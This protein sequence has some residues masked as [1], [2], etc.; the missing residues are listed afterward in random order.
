VSVD[1]ASQ[2][3]GVE[4]EVVDAKCLTR[5]VGLELQRTLSSSDLNGY[6]VANTCEQLNERVAPYRERLGI[7]SA[8]G[9]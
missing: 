4:V 5:S 2:V 9:R 8:S 7:N 3:H 1:G 6:A